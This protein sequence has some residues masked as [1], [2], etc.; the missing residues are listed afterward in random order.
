[1]ITKDKKIQIR[2]TQTDKDKIK[3][4]AEKVGLSMSNYI[5]KLILR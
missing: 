1:M 3:K 5:L 2:C 4:K